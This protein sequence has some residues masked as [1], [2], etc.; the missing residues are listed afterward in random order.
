MSD[1]FATGVSGYL[2]GSIDTAPTLINAPN[3]GKSPTNANQPNG[4]ASAVIQVETAL[5]SA[6]TLRGSFANLAARLAVLLGPSGQ[7]LLT[8]FTG[9]T[10]RYGLLATNT[11]TMVPT[12]H[13]PLGLIAPFAG[14]VVPTHWLLCDGAAVGRATYANLFG[15]ISTTYG[16]G[17]GSTTFNVPDLRGRIPMG[18]DGAAARVTSASTGGANADTLGGVGGA[19]THQLTTNEMPAHTHSNGSSGGSTNVQDGPNHEGADGTTGSTGGNAV[20]S[21]TQPWLAI[22]YIIFTGAL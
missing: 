1:L 10:T 9:L 4:L 12:N 13:S 3:P 15:V 14:S 18:I 8:G 2:T 6:V 20:H 16:V 7:L 19:Q 5:G 21:N 22:N 17:D 11:T